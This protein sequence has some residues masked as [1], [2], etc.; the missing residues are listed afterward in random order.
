MRFPASIGTPGVNRCVGC[1]R[2]PPG[3]SMALGI[4]AEC[5]RTR[6]PEVR[7]RIEEVHAASRAAFDLPAR[8]PRHPGGAKCVLCSNECVIGEGQRGFCGLRVMRAGKLVHLAGQPTR[9][10]LHWYRD[11]LPTNCV[12]DWV[13]E[14]TRQRGS[15]NL[16]V[17]YG[18]CTS[19]CLFCQN[20]HFRTMSPSAG[21]ILSAQELAAAADAGT[22]CV[23]FFGGD[24]SSQMPHALAVARYLAREGVRI[25]WE[26]NGMMH[27]KLLDAALERALDTGGCIKFDLKAFDEELHLALTGVSNRRTRENFARAARRFDERPEPPPVVASTLL[28]PGYINGDQ[29]RKIAGMIAGINAEIPYSLLAFAPGFAMSDISYTSK[30]QAEEA[31]AAAVQAGLTNVRIGNRHLLNLE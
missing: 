17:F 16:A 27:P 15:H 5:L 25:C 28:V 22:F 29:V 8:P 18:S 26:T 19:N 20:W 10:L 2:S 11:P 9:G 12:A 6:F 21:A 3:L 24:P 14:G 4:C 7:S 13:C 23:C 30:E 1:D 31:L